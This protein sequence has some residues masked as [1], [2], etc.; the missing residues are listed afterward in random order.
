MKTCS[1][2]GVRQPNSEFPYR[3]GT[4]R[5]GYCRGC[6]AAERES[7]RY[8][9]GWY[10][11]LSPE[12]KEE[13]R[14]ATRHYYYQN[15]EMVLA[16]VA[17]RRAARRAAM[18]IKPPKVSVWRDEVIDKLRKLQAEGLSA[19]QIA[20]QLHQAFGISVT[21]SAVLGKLHRMELSSGKKPDAAEPCGRA[22]A[23]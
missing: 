22:L 11:A 10:Q 21:R 5:A 19:A 1:Q 17:A 16:A 8:P 4:R 7:R 12:K 15:R 23:S 9:A 6:S 14:N 2:C 3:D 13:R 18:G 20:L